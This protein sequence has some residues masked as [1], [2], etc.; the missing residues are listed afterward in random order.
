MIIYGSKSNGRV[1]LD[2]IIKTDYETLIKLAGSKYDPEWTV[3][4][5]KKERYGEEKSK[6]IEKIKSESVDSAIQEQKPSRHSHENDEERI[7]EELNSE[8]MNP[9]E[10]FPDNETEEEENLEQL[11]QEDDETLE[12]DEENDEDQNSEPLWPT[13]PDQ[14]PFCITSLPDNLESIQLLA[15]ILKNQLGDIPVM[16]MGKERLVNDYGLQILREH[17]WK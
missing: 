7:E 3:V 4:R 5:A 8:E 15:D 17:F 11:D 1:Y 9:G 10:I 6:Q 14:E 12:I 16:I 13:T 2:K